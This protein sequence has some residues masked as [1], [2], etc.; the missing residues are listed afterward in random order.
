[1]A[2]PEIDDFGRLVSIKE[3]C[4]IL[5]IGRTS[6]F[7]LIADGSLDVCRIKG[8]TLI[9]LSSVHALIEESLV[10]RTDR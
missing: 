7:A 6:V 3:L 4:K 2:H 10:R 8:R 9:P 1:M 5:S